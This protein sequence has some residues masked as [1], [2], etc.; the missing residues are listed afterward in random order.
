M[1]CQQQDQSKFKYSNVIYSSMRFCI[2]KFLNKLEV[3]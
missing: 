3:S 1:Q 2:I